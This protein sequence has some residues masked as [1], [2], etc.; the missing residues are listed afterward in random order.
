MSTEPMGEPTEAE[1][2]TV[3]EVEEPTET[4]EAETPEAEA[5]ED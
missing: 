5:S 3:T 4:T 2:K 1:T